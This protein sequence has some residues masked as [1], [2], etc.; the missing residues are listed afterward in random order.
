MF[1]LLLLLF[2]AVPSHINPSSINIDH[3]N[4]SI[5]MMMC[6]TWQEPNISN[7]P[8][9]SYHLIASANGLLIKNETLKEKISFIIIW[10]ADE[11]EVKV[12]VAITAA[13]RN[14]KGVLLEGSTT[15]GSRQVQCISGLFTSFSRRNTIIVRCYSAS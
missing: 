3:I 5:N 11:A 2:H 12:E 13:N 8:I 7:G 10:C 4:G 14:K 15:S 6:V 1:L 9:D